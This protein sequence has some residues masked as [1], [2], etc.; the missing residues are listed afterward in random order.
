MSKLL[1]DEAPL[2]VDTVLAT[3]IGLDAALVLQHIHY[4]VE[5]NRK[6][7]SNLYEGS[8]WTYNS[9]K[10]WNKCFPFYTERTL[11]R[12][13]KKLKEL[14]VLK[15]GNFNK[16]KFDKTTWYT[17]DYEKLTS[18]VEGTEGESPSRQNG[19]IEERKCVNDDDKM[20][21]RERQNGET[22]ATKWQND[23]DKLATP[24]PEISTET[25]TEI[26][27]ETNIHTNINAPAG[28]QVDQVSVNVFICYEQNFGSFVP[29][30][31]K[32]NI[33][34]YLEDGISQELICHIIKQCAEN[35]KK[36]PYAKGILS[37]CVQDKVYTTQQ[38]E[39]KRE[40]F[41]ASKQQ[42][43]SEPNNGQLVSKNPHFTTTYSH[44]WDFDELDQMAQNYLDR[45]LSRGRDEFDGTQ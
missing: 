11:Q 18:I 29:Q 27:S 19:N 23:D 38:F 4:W 2:V 44:N 16:A 20:A 1:F 12:I 45:Q 43:K 3:K 32:D 40:Q 39:I 24:I 6:K 30:T 34:S 13:F 7:Q 22:T 14:G 42:N 41:R 33:I 31:I 37:A 28:K 21:E 25:S 36:W 17:I 26:S 35:Q 9:I 5:I 10:E 15:A 8:Y